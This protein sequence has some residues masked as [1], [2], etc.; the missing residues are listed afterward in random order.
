MGYSARVS[1]LRRL[2]LLGPTIVVQALFRGGKQS[3]T[4]FAVED[5]FYDF[6]F[7]FRMSSVPMV[8]CLGPVGPVGHYVSDGDMSVVYSTPA[9]RC[10]L[11]VPLKV[12]PPLIA[13][14]LFCMTAMACVAGCAAYGGRCWHDPCSVL[15]GQP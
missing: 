14:L 5:Y 7:N 12:H 10:W 2:H 9:P 13:R 15:I 8:C 6:Q 4:I 3:V 11:S 1:G